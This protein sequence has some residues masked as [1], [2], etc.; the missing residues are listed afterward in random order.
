MTTPKNEDCNKWEI[1]ISDDDIFAAMKDMEGFIDITLSDFRELYH[2]AF[3]HA[4]ERLF[5]DLTA[6]DIMSSEVIFVNEDTRL[7]AIVETMAENSISGVP[8]VDNHMVVSGVISEKDILHH[9]GDEGPK[10]FMGIFAECLGTKRCFA[11]TLQDLAAKSIMSSPSITAVAESTVIEIN[12]ILSDSYRT[13]LSVDDGSYSPNGAG[14]A[15][16]ASC[17]RPLIS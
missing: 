7:P 4:W 11:A 3:K 14:V 2:F 8:V 5:S 16:R 17:S 10:S 9:M 1:E 12:C 6:Q 15:R 13:L